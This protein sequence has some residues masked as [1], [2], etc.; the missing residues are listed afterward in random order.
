[1][2]IRELYPG[3]PPALAAKAQALFDTWSA[4]LERRRAQG[5]PGRYP[6]AANVAEMAVDAA[7]R[8]SGWRGDC[9]ADE[10]R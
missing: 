10:M 7:I 4:H 8:E 5:L 9:Q 1:M 6:P 2:T 3:L